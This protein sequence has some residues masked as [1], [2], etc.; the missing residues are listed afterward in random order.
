MTIF[1]GQRVGGAFLVKGLIPYSEP[2]SVNLDGVNWVTVKNF[3]VPVQLKEILIK[4]PTLA[5]AS[6]VYLAIF[7]PDFQTDG[8]ERWNSG[9]KAE[10]STVDLAMDHL[11][12]E[13]TLLK[14]KA[15]AAATETVTG[16]I[17]GIL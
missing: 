9:A 13:G 17:Y 8:D 5:N 4:I 10:T 7:D 12:L 6:N 1:G 3:G 15:D 14:I 11:L 16:V 2:F